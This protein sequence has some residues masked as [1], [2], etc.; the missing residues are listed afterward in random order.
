MIQKI[1]D[2]RTVAAQCRRL[3]EIGVFLDHIIQH[4]PGQSWM[5]AD[6]IGDPLRKR[7][8]TDAGSN[9][10]QF[11]MVPVDK[12][13]RHIGGQQSQHVFC[14]GV[15]VGLG[16]HKLIHEWPH[17]FPPKSSRGVA[18]FW[19]GMFDGVTLLGLQVIA[20]GFS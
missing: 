2:N 10:F 5:D 11:G 1:I 16:R 3:H 18:N 6:H 15:G 8:G 19:H 13:G 14:R 9:T 7:I 12:N 4:R 20:T 17:D